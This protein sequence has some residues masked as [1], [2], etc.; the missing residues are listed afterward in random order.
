MELVFRDV[1]RFDVLHFHCDYVHFPLVRR[2][3][4]AS[5]TT[6]HGYM[7]PHDLAPLLAEYREVPL[8]SLSD[9]QRVPIPDANWLATI[10]HGLPRDLF[11]F[12]ETG[13]D[14]LA[15]LGRLSPEKGVE[16][17]I[18]IARLS[19]V[20]LKIAAKIYPEEQAY[21][22]A[23]VVPA[24]RAAGSLVELIGEVGGREKNDFLG[25][26]RALLFPIEW[27]EPFGL[28]MIEALACGTPVVAWP[29]GSVPEIVADGVTGYIVDTV[30]DAALAVARVA[31]TRP[32]GL[33]RRLRATFRCGANGATVRRG[34]P[35]PYPVSVRRRRL[36]HHSPGMT[37][38]PSSA[39]VY[40]VLAASP[41]GDARTRVLKHADTFAVF[42]H[43]GDIVP[44][45]LGEEGLYHEGTRFLSRFALTLEM[46]RPFFLSSQIRA[47]SSE[48]TTV[49]TNPDLAADGHLRLQMGTLYLV[50]KKFL[51]HGVLYQRVQVANHGL[52]PV[53]SMLEWHY[54][55][56][57][58]DIFEVRGVTR[59]VRGQYLAPEVSTDRVVLGYLGL[60]GV[61]RRT[62]LEFRPP[63]SDVTDSYGRY[64]LALQ[65]R[66]ELA[67]ELSVTCQATAAEHPRVLAF[68]VAREAA[69]AERRETAATW[70]QGGHVERTGPPMARACVGRFA[71]A[72]DDAAFGTVPLRGSAVV[73]HAVR[74][75]RDCDGLAMSLAESR[76]RARRAGVPRIYTGTGDAGGGRCSA[77]KDSS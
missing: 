54:R 12:R 41:P 74:P 15:F 72:D 23:R 76:A 5:V 50:V 62:R 24:V 59:Q 6:M 37:D 11:G 64:R 9:N 29:R 48:L 69:V 4:C 32:T 25:G 65:P 14:Y 33:P 34:V 66:E 8:V 22:E 19:N 52:E 38:E 21:V 67:F 49:L 18:E 44:G 20:P 55:T 77:R 27:A 47:H 42:D 1:H 28:V 43:Y 61:E 39:S 71:N 7:H 51:W 73:Q 53:V 46:Q 63:L 56:D 60:D 3:G 16:R 36:V 45:G 13:G 2:H 70:G 10:H 75:G 58:A 68:S 30:Q 31:N 40:H 35:T 57:F 17:A 26:A